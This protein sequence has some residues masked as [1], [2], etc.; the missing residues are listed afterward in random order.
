VRALAEQDRPIWSQ[1]SFPAAEE[2]FHAAAIAGIDA[3]VYWPG[4]GQV[5]A[6]ELVVRRLLPL[7]AAGLAEWG[8]S[9]AESGELLDIIERRCVTGVNGAGWFVDQVRAREAEGD[10]ETIMRRVLR[11][12]RERMHANDP[13]H[14]WAD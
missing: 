5:P 8:V 11:D 4:V 12:Y 2:N 13:V 3:R 14:T 6:T 7:A 9:D 10:R 1:M